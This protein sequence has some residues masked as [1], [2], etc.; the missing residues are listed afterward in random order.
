VTRAVS[1]DAIGRAPLAAGG[2]TRARLGALLAVMADDRYP[3]VR[4]I[5]WRGLHRL[6][7]PGGSSRAADYD[8]SG[9]A[10]ARGGVVARARAELGI[11]A[12]ARPRSRASDQDLEIGE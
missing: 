9:T 6:P 10:A 5:A 4:H 2:D 3:A 1:A 12:A 8:P 7:G 11:S